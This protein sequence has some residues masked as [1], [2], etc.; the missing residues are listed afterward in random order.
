MYPSLLGVEVQTGLR[1]TV[2]YY[3]DINQ[4]STFILNINPLS[5]AILN[6]DQMLT[7]VESQNLDQLSVLVYFYQ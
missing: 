7:K 6:F 1:P 5:T 2:D 3:F 4:H